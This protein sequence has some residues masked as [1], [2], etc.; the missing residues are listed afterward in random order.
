MTAPSS[1]NQ[2]A[3][4]CQADGFRLGHRGCC[5]EDQ[6]HLGTLNVQ[7]PLPA[8]RVVAETGG[9]Q[10]EAAW[11]VAIDAV[12][13]EQCEAVIHRSIET[14]CVTR[15]IIG[16]QRAQGDGER[17]AAVGQ[18]GQ[19]AIDLELVITDTGS[20]SGVAQRP[21]VGAAALERGVASATAAAKRATTTN[22]KS[23]GVDVGAVELQDAASHGG[24]A[25][26]RVAG[27]TQNPGAAAS[28]GQ[29]Q[30]GAAVGQ[31]TTELSG[32]VIEIDRERG[33]LAAA[34]GDEP[35]TGLSRANGAQCGAVA[36]QVEFAAALRGCVKGELAGAGGRTLGVELKLGFITQG[37]VRAVDDALAARHEHAVVLEMELAAGEHAAL[38]PLVAVPDLAGVAQVGDDDEVIAKVDAGGVAGHG[39]VRELQAAAATRGR[40]AGVEGEAI[41]C[42][43][44]TC[45]HDT[46]SD[47]SGRASGLHA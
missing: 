25:T 15:Q 17:L 35:C 8:T 13:G 31:A 46:A 34:V 11:V 16:T 7:R 18:H 9:E 3:R 26:V 23:A 1:Q 40:R 22:L 14:G 2:Q 41:L 36:A 33:R 37:D 44:D 32:V 42:D 39:Q 47:C 29:G 10:A 6:I 12:R 38:H 45:G 4:K 30:R 27:T 21:D 24:G 43:G 5:G 28:F 19:H 20:T